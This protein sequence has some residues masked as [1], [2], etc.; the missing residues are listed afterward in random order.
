MNAKTKHELIILS[1]G[2]SLCSCVANIIHQ[3]IPPIVKAAY[4]ASIA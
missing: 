2:Q 1:M 3:C 4:N